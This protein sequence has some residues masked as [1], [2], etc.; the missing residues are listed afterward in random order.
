MYNIPYWNK[1]NKKFL[2]K[3]KKKKWNEPLKGPLI[4]GRR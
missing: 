3:K 4:G 1:K 2:K